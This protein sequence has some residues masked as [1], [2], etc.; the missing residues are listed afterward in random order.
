MNILIQSIDKE[1][2]ALIN[3]AQSIFMAYFLNLY[4]DMSSKKIGIDTHISE[5]LNSIFEKEKSIFLNDPKLYA[6]AAYVENKLAGFSFFGPLENEQI[7]LLRTLPIDLI[8]KDREFDIR[9]HILSYIQSLF[10]SAHQIIIM[11]RKANKKHEQFCLRAG[12]KTCTDIFER[13][14]YIQRSYSTLSYNAYS[15]ESSNN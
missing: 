6:C 14:T 1:N 8:H 11:V 2:K 5:Y 13:S 7:I 3:A 4:G 15:C 9:T 10:P 12:F